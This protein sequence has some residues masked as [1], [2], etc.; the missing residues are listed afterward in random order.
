MVKLG[1]DVKGDKMNLL[2]SEASPYLRQHKDNPVHWMPWGEPAFARARAENKPVLLSIGYA[3]CHWCHVMAHESFEDPATAGLMNDFFVNVKVDREEFPDV[4]G[5]YQNALALMGVQGGWPATLFLTPAGEAFWGGTYFPPHARHGLP[6]FREVLRGVAKAWTEERE[7]ITH[8][9]ESVLRAMRALYAPAAGA[10][11][12]PEQCMK[13]G[14]ALLS[15]YDPLCG[16]FGDAETPKFPCLPA[17]ALL[18]DCHIRSGADKYKAAV[19]HSL[20]SMCQGGLYDHIGGGFFR[21]TVD[22]GWEIPHFEKM[23]ADN[24]LFIDM[25]T[26]VFRETKNPLFALRTEQTIEWLLREMTVE[27]DDAAAFASSLDADS[28][29]AAGVKSEGAFYIWRAGDVDAALG[30]D[31]ADFRAALD[32]GK[33]GNWPGNPGHNIPNRLSQPAWRGD[34]EET[35][36]YALCRKLRHLRAARPAPARDDKVICDLNALAA[37]A[38]CK[39]GFVFDRAEWTRAGLSCYAYIR[40]QLMKSGGL[41]RSRCEGRSGA[42]ARLDDEAHFC[43]CAL[44]LYEFT[45]QD[46][47]LND[48]ERAARRILDGFAAVDG[49]FY[50]S[51]QEGLLLPLR[52]MHADDHALPSGNSVAVRAL[53]KLWVLTGAEEYR[54]PAEAASR[55]FA[56]AMSEHVFPHAGMISAALALQ[57]PL[58]AVISGGDAAGREELHAALRDLS[59]PLHVLIVADTADLPPQHPAYGKN[60]GAEAAV[61]LCTAGRCLAPV[62]SVRTFREMVRAERQGQ[63]RPPANDE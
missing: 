4:D 45:G 62:T 41:V 10:L 40:K 19:L 57:T 2:G 63:H 16:G 51:P 53:A 21:Y 20:T 60:S 18:W 22:G 52:P 3:A 24:A 6:S 1:H 5:L 8:N 33:F 34:E 59:A 15:R 32:I 37:A 25:L 38:L 26:E 50:A 42:P 47:L 56:G 28:M 13:I 23:L 58:C 27:E 46:E 35:R 43:L 29:T 17:L 36:L 54:A 7:K 48:A 61:W 55:V 49:G 14:D 9:G 30:A 12:L 44:S 39:A 31:A 11:P